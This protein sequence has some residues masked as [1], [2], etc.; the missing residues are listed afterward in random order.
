MRGLQHTVECASLKCWNQYKYN[1]MQQNKTNV[2]VPTDTSTLIESSN[3]DWISEGCYQWSSINQNIKKLI[4]L[5]L[6]IQKDENMFF[7]I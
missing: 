4:F 1:K 2:I 3:F 7:I 5:I 6:I